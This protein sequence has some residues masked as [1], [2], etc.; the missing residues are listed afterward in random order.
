[1]SVYVRTVEELI[2]VLKTLPKDTIVCDS[3]SDNDGL[4][5]DYE[6]NLNSVMFKGSW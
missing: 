3:D 4:N 1:M 2:E 5:L 6:E